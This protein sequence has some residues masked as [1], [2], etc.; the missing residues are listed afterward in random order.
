MGIDAKGN[1][2][3]YCNASSYGEMLFIF[4]TEK[5]NKYFLNGGPKIL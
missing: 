4:I 3:G 5:A 2:K 1:V